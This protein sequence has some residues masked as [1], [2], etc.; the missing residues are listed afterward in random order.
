MLASKKKYNTEGTWELVKSVRLIRS[1]KGKK[2]KQWDPATDDREAILS[3][4]MG[5]S[6]NLR[7]PT[8]KI[9][10]T[11]LVGFNAELYDEVF[12]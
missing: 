4:I 7:A 1:G 11:I 5:P 12:G 9:G 2:Q 6:G 3:D 8:W 10:D